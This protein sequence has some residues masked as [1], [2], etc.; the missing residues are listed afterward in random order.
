MRENTVGLSLRR[1]WALQLAIAAMSLSGGALAD[2]SEAEFQAIT[3]PQETQLNEIRDQEVNQIKVILKRSIGKEERADLL[4]RLGEVYNEKYR[5][6]FYKENQIWNKRI[7]EFLKQD[8]GKKKGKRP[9][10]DSGKSRGYLIQSI[11]YLEKVLNSIGK[12]DKLDEVYYYLGFN[13]WELGNQKKS[14][15]YFQRIANGYP[16]SRYLTESHRYIADY[17]FANRRFKQSLESY[18]R[19]ARDK[20]SPTMPKILY[21]MS[22]SFYKI[23][24]NRRALDTIIQA[25]R[26]SRSTTEEEAVKR[27]TSLQNDAYDALVLFYSEAGK[28]AD[29]QKF[30]EKEVG[31]EMAPELLSKLL[32]IYQRQGRY[33]EALTTSKQLESV[34]SSAREEGS[35]QRYQILAN[36]LKLA[37]QKRDTD[38]EQGILK[39]L[40]VEFIQ[41]DAGEEIR[42]MV[43]VNLRN[44]ALQAHKES[45]QSG[46]KKAAEAR[47]IGLY[48]LYIS[49]FSGKTSK[50]DIYEI[51]YFL[52]DLYSQSGRYREAAAQYRFLL[53]ASI[54]DSGNDFLKKVKRSAAEGVIYTLDSYFDARKSDRL[55]RAELDDLLEAIDTF[56]Q[57]YPT[58]KDAPKFVA[59]AAGLLKDDKERAPEYHER[60]RLLVEKYPGTQQGMEAAVLLVKNAEEKN[61]FAG[62]ERLVES[63]LSNERLMAQDRKG[64]FRAQLEAVSSKAKFK[65][66]KDIEKDSN[67]AEAGKRFEE[68]AKE[69]KDREVRFKA[70]NNAAVNYQKAGDRANEL[71]LYKAIAKMYPD[72]GEASDR[73]LSVADESFILG[74]YSEAAEK[75]EEFYELVEPRLASGGDKMQNLAVN[76]LRNA[77]FLREAMKDEERAGENI[78]K[79]VQAANK[80]VASAR[81]AAEEFLF[82][83]ATNHRRAGDTVEAVNGYKRYLSIFPAGKYSIESMVHLGNLYSDLREPEKA[84]SFLAKASAGKT[85][86]KSLSR[87]ELG[88]AAEARLALLSGLESA[89]RRSTINLPE[90]Q[91]KKDI[92]N[93]LQ[94]MEQ[95]NKGYLEV[96]EYGDGK[97]ALEAFYKMAL[98]YQDFANQLEN[99]PIPSS[100][101]AEEKAKFQAQLRVVAKPVQLKVVETLQTALKQGENLVVGDPSMAKIY[102]ANAL[103]SPE[104]GLPLVQEADFSDA[105]KWV[106][107]GFGDEAGAR[108]AL[109]L[110]AKNAKALTSV[111]NYHLARN[112]ETFA[113]IFFNRALQ[114]NPKFVPALNNLAYLE[115]KNGNMQAAL[116]GFKQAL[117]LKEFEIT[118]K[119]NMAKIYMASGLWRHARLAYQQLEVRAPKDEEVLRGLGM[120]YL[121][122][123]KG[124]RAREF[125]SGRIGTDLNGKYARAVIELAGGDKADARSAFSSIADKSEYARLILEHW[126]K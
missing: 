38:R 126:K 116:A 13:H 93:K 54:D 45:D 58:D 98:T 40:I 23:G 18:Q 15:G 101:D 113:R 8:Q 85:K 28:P 29:A 3:S 89:Y 79:I 4:L 47:A 20:N 95:L 61:D 35:E 111:G 12:Y 17:E 56:V 106:M 22:W 94:R 84:Q 77:A 25:I 122:A 65:V 26:L 14:I 67:F 78:R 46:N 125:L 48:K 118:P 100:Y 60:L 42:E 39:T 50:D 1:I 124:D 32:S 44:S 24:Q 74:E 43:R 16:N 49:T 31:E 63:Y 86:G 103:I 112:E 96:V 19:A 107:G 71:R 52:A 108:A 33:A 51:Q 41:K 6:Y 11:S 121:A 9:K 10:L 83:R 27:G 82:E 123:G 109:K 7:D 69:S 5:S 87:S 2:Y 92:K 110:N 120:S 117:A 53:K 119:N 72:R 76:A 105:K 36:A 34:D 97:W 75:Y 57:L 81:V 64:E 88:Y 55:S 37:Q 102:V 30:L 114:V 90:E 91:L 62:I 80:K 59:R 104:L 66:V 21:G 70:L 115:G 73:I 68:L 99:A